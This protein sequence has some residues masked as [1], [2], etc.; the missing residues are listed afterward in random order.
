[1]F[2]CR[3]YC[4]ASIRTCGGRSQIKFHIRR[5]NKK[6]LVKA[7]LGRLIDKLNQYNQIY[8]IWSMSPKDIV[9]LLPKEFSELKELNGIED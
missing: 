5:K 7:S 1:M 8:D 2:I 3:W 4:I 9:S 6:T